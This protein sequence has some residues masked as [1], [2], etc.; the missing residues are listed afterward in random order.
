MLK[1]QKVSGLGTLKKTLVILAGLVAILHLSAILLNAYLPSD[2]TAQLISWFDLDGERNIPTVYSGL[3]LGCCAFISFLLSTRKNRTPERLRWAFLALLFFYLAFDEIL[4]IHEVF[5]E[6]IR[7]FLSIA[8]DSPL[9]HAWVI[10]AAAVG[11]AIGGFAYFIRHHSEISQLQRTVFAYIAILAGGVIF[12]EILGTQLYFSNTIYK[13][14]PVF[15][16]EMFEIT[17]SSLILYK[18]TSAT[19]FKIPTR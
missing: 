14:G 11:L 16:E 4:V 8:A 5:A 2:Q 18:L 15:I 10:P 12:L 7:D 13:L 6:P 9:F 3:I 19:N 1:Q 17:M